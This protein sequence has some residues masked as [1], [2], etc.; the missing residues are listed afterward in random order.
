MG[1]LTDDQFARAVAANP[2]WKARLGPA[3]PSDAQFAAVGLRGLAGPQDHTFVDGIAAFQG[4]S[5]LDVDGICGKE[6]AAKV[7]G[8]ALPAVG[9]RPVLIVGG[10]ELPAPGCRVVT[11]KDPD[12]MGFQA[13]G[14]WRPRLRGSAVDLLVLHHDGCR[15]SRQ[16]FDVLLQRGLSV[17]LMLDRDGTIY[18]A[19]DLREA[20]AF[21]AGEVNARS[22]G[23]EICNPELVERNDPQDPRPVVALEVTNAGSAGA[24]RLVL[25]F[26]KEQVAAT[27]ALAKA[28]S[29]IFGLPSRL[30]QATSSTSTAGVTRGVDP[31]V[32]ANQYSGTC[33]HYHVKDSKVDPGVSLWPALREAGFAV[34]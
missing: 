12:G 17:H 11:W 24:R 6:T 9:G 5:G 22:V 28:V 18:Q 33:G 14:G 23:V 34:G 13:Q 31:R 1:T 21:H 26:Y 19:L 20:Q 32:A 10:E 4:R 3:W 2:R 7:R 27:I 16:C 25:G 29:G 15:S 8:V 30:P